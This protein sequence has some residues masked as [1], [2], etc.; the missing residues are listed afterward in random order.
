MNTATLLLSQVKSQPCAPAI[1]ETHKGTDRIV[2]FAELDELSARGAATLRAA[3]LKPG[4]AALVFQPMSIDLYV[5]LVALFRAGV[6]AMFLDPSAGKEHIGRC[7]ALH[8]PD[9]FLGSPKAH[10]LRLLSPSIRRIPRRF[11]FGGIPLPGASSW[12]ASLKAAKE[13]TVIE[14]CDAD[15][16]ALLTFTSG[17]TGQPK[18]TVRT[19]GLL[20]AQHEALA[21]SI[22]LVAGQIDLT[23][24]PIFALA[25]LASGV[26]SLIPEGDLRSPAAIDPAPVI[27]QI[28]RHSP[29]RSGGS[30]AFFERLLTSGE[31]F[32]EFT[33]LYTG[34]A[35]VFPVLLDQ[36]RKSAPNA[37]VVAVY[38]STEAEPIAHIARDQMD[39][40]D[41]AAMVAGKGL[42]A[43]A[44]EPCVNLRVLRDQW[45]TAVGPFTQGEFNEL[46]C[47]TGE[48][49]EI[50]VSGAHVLPCYL[51]GVGD[52][53][54]KF[55]VEGTVW[56]RTG[57]SGY[58]DETGR[59]W[60]LG[61]ASARVADE[62]GVLY[63]FAVECAARQ[64][65]GIRRAALAFHQGKRIL[66][67]EPERNAPS[68]DTDALRSTLAWA[69][70]DE[71][72]LWEQ[73]PMDKRHNA[74]V[75][76]TALQKR[77]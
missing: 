71:I 69:D 22:R 3:G 10:L 7:C 37:R 28:R 54:T 2:T 6:I 77:L 35:P 75:D 60:L 12:R 38:G 30:P 15:T 8:P 55:K 18:A 36:M 68:P 14:T 50:V 72:R 43:G 46:C 31:T 62:R 26:T 67:L 17:S 16:A 23:T 74:K 76:Y 19:H 11:V 40:G 44:P 51:N 27:A 9:A 25:N 5:A 58:R 49:G 45:G 52:A 56:H 70:L 39:D 41:I 34:G 13:D 33:E 21:E 29:S 53:E 42:L 24:L 57:D 20:Q 47:P 73:I 63:P 65:P 64:Q 32:P 61:R 66:L 4:H 48:A 1:I 59:L